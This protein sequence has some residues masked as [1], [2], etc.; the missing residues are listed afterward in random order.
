LELRDLIVT[1]IILGFIFVV[2][3]LIRPLVT[4][5]VTHR[6]FIPALTLKIVGAISLGLIYTFYYKG[7]DTFKYHTYGS[8]HIWEAIMDSPVDGFDLLFSSELKGNFYKYASRMIVFYDKPS[9]FVAR[10]ATFF[11][12]L[13]FSS[14][15]ATAALFAVLSFTGMWMFFVTFYRKYPHLHKWMAVAALFI[16]S[17]IFWG[18]GIMKDS[19]TLAFVG[20]GTYAANKLFIEKRFSTGSLLLLILSFYIIF[21]VKKYILLCFAPAVVIWALAHYLF[22]LRSQVLKIMLA[23][24][25][26]FATVI[27]SY[28]VVLKIGEKDEKYALT[29]IAKTATI[30]AYDIL[31]VTGKEAGSGYALGALDGTFSGMLKLLPQAINVSLFRP[32]FWEVH[33]P[34]MLLSAIESFLLLCF[35]LLVIVRCRFKILGAL[36]NADT[37]F[38]LI[39][40]LSFAFAVGVS[41]YNFGTL[42]R[43]KIPMLPFYLIALVLIWDYSKSDKNVGLLEDTE[44][45]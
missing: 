31:Y 27:L 4:D 42:V 37:L 17:L 38:A 35:T 23:P 24:V 44:K 16:P 40:S 33:N 18:S 7:G 29:R 11:D 15:S 8:R 12:L 45:F 43:Y 30:T 36:K 28:F 13:T 39:F 41:T 6:Y 26:V 20:M 32:Y 19:V 22:R 2:A 10:I 14:Y 9:F 25:I 5:T 1:P 3:Y 34:L 21:S